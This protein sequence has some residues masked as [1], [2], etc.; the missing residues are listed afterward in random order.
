MGDEMCFLPDLYE[1]SLG[2]VTNTPPIAS[3]LQGNNLSASTST[4]QLYLLF[5][6][7]HINKKCL[8]FLSKYQGMTPSWHNPFRFK[9][10]DE[11]DELLWLQF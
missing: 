4:F 10:A 6:V 7:N 8:A 11:T 2:V 1:Y 3:L 9:A 5:I